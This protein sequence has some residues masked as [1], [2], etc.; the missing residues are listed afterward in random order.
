MMDNC[1][2]RKLKKLLRWAIEHIE[3]GS[4]STP[5]AHECEYFTNPSLGKCEFHDNYWESKNILEDI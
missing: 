3:N 5:P 4:T 1:E 2:V